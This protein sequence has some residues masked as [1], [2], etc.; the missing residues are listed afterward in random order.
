MMVA[1]S[2]HGTRT[3]GTVSVCE[4]AWSM[5]KTSLMLVVPCCMSTHSASKPWRAITSAVSPWDTESQPIVTHLPS[6]HICLILFGRIVS[7]LSLSAVRRTGEC[8]KR[9]TGPLAKRRHHLFAEQAERPLHQVPPDLAARVQLRQ[10]P[11]QS[12]QGAQL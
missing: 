1:G 8:P 10:N 3:T 2:F 9:S 7:S 5:G 11:V 6:R 4:T 12:E